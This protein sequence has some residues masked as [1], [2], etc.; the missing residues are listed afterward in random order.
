MAA[1]FV[2]LLSSH[3]LPAPHKQPLRAPVKLAGAVLSS[4]QSYMPA[5][6]R[7][8][9]VCSLDLQRESAVGW[10]GLRE[11]QDGAL[12]GT[13]VRAGKHTVRF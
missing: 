3:S 6:V 9:L 5:A 13:R 4:R 2:F 7:C 10:C 8:S 12:S 1:W 11:L